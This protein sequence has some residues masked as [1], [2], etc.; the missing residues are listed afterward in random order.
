MKKILFFCLSF[1]MVWTMPKTFAKADKRMP[2]N[3]F[4]TIEEYVEYDGRSLDK[5]LKYDSY[6]SLEE[7]IEYLVECGR[8]QQEEEII[9]AGEN[10]IGTYVREEKTITFS[11]SGKLSWIPRKPYDD[12]TKIVIEEGITEIGLGVGGPHFH[13][14]QELIIPKSVEKIREGIFDKSNYNLKKVYNYSSVEYDPRQ[15]EYSGWQ[16]KEEYRSVEEGSL[17]E[18]V[19]PW[20]WMVDGK[21]VTKIPPNSEATAIPKKYHIIYNLNRGKKGKGEWFN[22]YRYG[23]TKD[24]PKPERKGYFFVGWKADGV[25]HPQKVFS[26]IV[27]TQLSDVKLKAI[28]RKI[29]IVKNKNGKGFRVLVSHQRTPRVTV[30]ISKKNIEE[31]LKGEYELQTYSL[32]FAERGRISFINSN[33][34]FTE[35]QEG[36]M[37]VL[38]IEKYN[39]FT[40]FEK[41]K[42]Y[43]I[44]FKFIDPG[45]EPEQY[46]VF[47]IDE[48]LGTFEVIYIDENGY[49]YTDIDDYFFYKTKITF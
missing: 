23:V 39:E 40:E 13:G 45:D 37:R 4:K 43:H 18:Y 30:Y 21:E 10:V 48:E 24:L 5:I 17:L 8:M 33:D 32:G 49:T 12:V 26:K 46:K 34:A 25:V 29:K 11:G 47:D 38:N 2:V 15:Y 19:S 1:I 9:K 36:R 42:T 6:E 16:K 28:W 22:S 20:R 44:W 31:Q 14:L 7:L 3:G 27:P 35:F 41:G